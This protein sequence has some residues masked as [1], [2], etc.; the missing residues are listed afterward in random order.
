MN[1]MDTE[2][3][4]RIDTL[5]GL[6]DV[7]IDS[8]A[9]LGGIMRVV[10][11][12]SSSL[13]RD[14]IGYGSLLCN[15]CGDLRRASLECLHVMQIDAGDIDRNNITESVRRAA[16]GSF[17]QYTCLQCQARS[18]AVVYKGRGGLSLAV[19][20]EDCNRGPS[21]MPQLLSMYLEQ[22]RLARAAGAFVA[23]I[24]MYR[25]AL[26]VLLEDHGYRQGS[27]GGPR[28][29]I[30]VLESQ[31]ETGECPTWARD[32]GVEYFNIIRH[33]GNASV[34]AAGRDP[35]AYTELD[36]D[37]C[38]DVEQLFELI[39]YLAYNADSR[40][41]ETIKELMKRTQRFK[42]KRSE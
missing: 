32:L 42:R 26:E 10:L 39:V 5:D 18:F 30:A 41:E 14:N 19:L 31:L 21:R 9:L 16:I 12:S 4:N 11:A 38:N 35:S 15:Q 37:M 13:S 23:A 28:G 29:K 25:S 22:A 17:Y 20:S 34:H 33:L 24:A 40:R 2:N 8:P 27:L 1:H 7:L 3:E 6:L 36:V